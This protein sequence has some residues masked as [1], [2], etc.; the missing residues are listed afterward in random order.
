MTH[1]PTVHTHS[2]GTP[3]LTSRA[4]IA[5]Y[6]TA[7]SCFPAAGLALVAKLEADSTFSLALLHGEEMGKTAGLR[8][9]TETE[10][11]VLYRTALITA[12]GLSARLGKLASSK[13]Y[14]I[15]Q[16]FRTSSL[17]QLDRL[18]TIVAMAA[19]LA[20]L[21]ISPQ[22]SPS[23]QD[24]K[25]AL[26]QLMQAVKQYRDSLIAWIRCLVE[27]PPTTE[28]EGPF[29]PPPSA[30]LAEETALKAAQNSVSVAT[31][32]VASQC[33]GFLSSLM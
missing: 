19:S 25:R 4:V 12:L 16:P 6:W 24:C 21:E 3:C 2:L 14:Q 30:C 20:R 27:H 29:G 33:G 32:Q 7:S 11:S 26:F 8:K 15:N 31:S 1:E 9:D 13:G 23:G 17:E 18:T 5:S 10:A 22:W 28:G